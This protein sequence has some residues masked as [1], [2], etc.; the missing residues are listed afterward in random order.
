MMKAKRKMTGL[1]LAW[2]VKENIVFVKFLVHIRSFID[3]KTWFYDM[4]SRVCR[5]GG[6]EIRWSWFGRRQNKM[7]KDSEVFL[8]KTT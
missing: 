1:F 6:G 5:R 7:N 4:S 8:L 2:S 3:G